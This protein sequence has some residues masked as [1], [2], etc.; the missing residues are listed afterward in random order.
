ML[1]RFYRSKK[2]QIASAM[3]LILV[4]LGIIAP[5]VS[6]YDYKQMRAGKLFEP[7]SRAH[8]LGTDEYGRD[9]LAR[10]LFGIRFS[11]STATAI[12]L[13][14]MVIGTVLGTISGYYR[15]FIDSF[16][17]SVADILF[18]LPTV[19][20][21]LIAMLILGPGLRTAIAALTFTYIPQFLRLARSCTLAVS[22]REFVQAAKAIGAGNR[23]IISRH[24]F[25]NIIVPLLVQ[26]ALSMSLAI[27]DES[28]LSFVGLGAQPPTP[29]WGLMIRTG[30][31]YLNRAQHLA[32]VPGLA[33]VYVV[34]AFNLLSD[35][36][37]EA[38]QF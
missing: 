13:L 23:R 37:Q 7:P 21:A 2:F 24:I 32:V 20:W 8:P 22:V 35:G 31:E 14:A 34:L 29:S 4:T 18:S 38:F 33:I 36:L 12:A 28:V 3:L 10:I 6:P 1:Q 16:L 26:L 27:I 15:G 9:I 17:S 19:L 25:P 30:L 11:L 5:I